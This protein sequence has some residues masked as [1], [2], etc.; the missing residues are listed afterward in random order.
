M[1]L[2]APTIGK[3]LGTSAA[4]IA[5]NAAKTMKQKEGIRRVSR[6]T[7]KG[8][9]EGDRRRTQVLDRMKDSLDAVFIH[10]YRNVD[11]KIRLKCVFGYVVVPSVVRYLFESS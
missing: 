3:T 9:A 11:P 2:I 7:K 10:R 8:I 5:D 1:Q 6:L 4:D